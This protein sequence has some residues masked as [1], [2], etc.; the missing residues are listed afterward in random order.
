MITSKTTAQRCSR[1]YCEH[2]PDARSHVAA[3]G[4]ARVCGRNSQ[5]VATGWGRFQMVA[6]PAGAG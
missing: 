1:K 2:S 6:T 5:M 3:V 4:K